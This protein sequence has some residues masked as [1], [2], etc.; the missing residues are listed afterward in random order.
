MNQNLKYQNLL[1]QKGKS[2]GQKHQAGEWQTIEDKG[3]YKTV[4]R[5]CENCGQKTNDKV[6]K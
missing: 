2:K 6:L 3:W 1:C 5:F 4:A